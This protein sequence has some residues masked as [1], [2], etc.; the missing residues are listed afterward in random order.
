[1]LVT[2]YIG[3]GHSIRELK[4]ILDRLGIDHD[5]AAV[6]LY[7]RPDDDDY[8]SFSDR[9]YFGTVGD[10]GLAF[11]GGSQRESAGV[12]KRDDSKSAHPSR[13]APEA[14]SVNEKVKLARQDIDILAKEIEK[15]L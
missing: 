11:Y 6:S 2:E 7:S 15:I 5:V 13:L 3:S 10:D 12:Q 14:K 1:M 8:I 4:S 9:L